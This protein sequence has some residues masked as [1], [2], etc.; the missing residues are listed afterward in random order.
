[1]RYR[2]SLAP[3]IA[4]LLLLLGASAAAQTIRD[5]ES[6]THADKV[7]SISGANQAQSA[8]AAPHPPGGPKR[9]IRLPER[10]SASELKHLLMDLPG[11]FQLVDI[12][13]AAHFRD[14]NLEG[15][16]NVDIADLISNP[17]YLA[18]AGPLIVVDRDGSLA[19]AAAG[20]LSQKTRRP[21]KCLHG[22]LEAYWAESELRR[23]VREVPLPGAGAGAPAPARTAPQP[24]APASPQPAKP[25]KKSAGC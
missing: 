19:M 16:E 11:T 4:A 3:A 12:R 24:P 22:G 7:S 9:D 20:I 1:M 25:A 6:A 14:F 8:S 15:S 23:A 21:I 5:S 18:G 2:L 10:I 17:A 13:P